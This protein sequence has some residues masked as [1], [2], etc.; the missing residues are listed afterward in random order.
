MLIKQFLNVNECLHLNEY[1][2]SLEYNLEINGQGKAYDIENLSNNFLKKAILKV[3]NF[4]FENYPQHNF[5]I[6]NSQFVMLKPNEW[7]SAH[8][9]W[10][11][12]N[13]QVNNFNILLQK[14]QNGGIILHD[15]SQVLLD[16]GDAYILDAS[17]IHGITTVKG[18]KD[19]YSLLLWFYK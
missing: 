18:N 3:C 5:S 14:P 9:D 12:K 1:A 6:K 2:K 19:F 7:V 16:E 8:K 13:K 15:K 10:V 11:E 17:L 4:M